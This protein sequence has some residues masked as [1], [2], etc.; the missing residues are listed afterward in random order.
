MNTARILALADRIEVT[1]FASIHNKCSKGLAPNSDCEAH[2]EGSFDMWAV[3]YDCGTPACLVGHCHEM[4]REGGGMG[5]AHE[6][7][8]LENPTPGDSLFFPNGP[9]AN[10]NARPGDP[11]FISPERAAATLRRLAESKTGEVDWGTE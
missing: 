2:P 8:G 9:N 4:A 7:L 11:A 1:T 5:P 6:Y 3:D 10:M